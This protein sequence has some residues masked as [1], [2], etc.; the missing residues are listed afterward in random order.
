MM[1]KLIALVCGL[2]PMVA[3]AVT[4]YPTGDSVFVSTQ[5]ADWQAAISNNETIVIDTSIAHPNVSAIKSPNGFS[6]LNNVEFYDVITE[7]INNNYGCIENNTARDILKKYCI[8][9]GFNLINEYIDDGYSGTT[10]DR[11][12]FQKMI[13]DIE[14]KKINLVLT[15]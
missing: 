5:G 1:K 7:I 8:S 3:G 6:I 2:L 9:N 4:V 12:G 10:F 15:N 11:P 13:E 14:L